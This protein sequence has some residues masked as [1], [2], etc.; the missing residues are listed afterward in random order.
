MC[1][2]ILT[3]QIFSISMKKYV[4][5]KICHSPD[6]FIQLKVYPAVISLGFV[7]NFS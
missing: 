6:L 4:S 7:F 5:M 2:E 1:C 3:F